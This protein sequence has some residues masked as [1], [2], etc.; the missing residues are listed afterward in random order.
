LPLNAVA[1][2]VPVT[3]WF[4]VNYCLC[5]LNATWCSGARRESAGRGIVIGRDNV[6][7]C[8]R[9]RADRVLR[10]TRTSPASVIV[11]GFAEIVIVPVL[12]DRNPVPAERV[13]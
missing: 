10:G 1:V 4:A 7:A 8:R 12:G 13:D 11:A 6:V 5:F 9:R 3:V 2:T